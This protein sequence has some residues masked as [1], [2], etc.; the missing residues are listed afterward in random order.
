MTISKHAPCTDA[1][2]PKPGDL[3]AKRRGTDLASM[4]SVCD[5]FKRLDER[6]FTSII[7]ENYD[8]IAPKRWYNDVIRKCWEDSTIDREF[9]RRRTSLLLNSVAREYQVE[10]LL[11]AISS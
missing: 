1:D 5:A 4:A 8:K 10:I 9:K 6:K 7:E 2:S 3:R 11:Q